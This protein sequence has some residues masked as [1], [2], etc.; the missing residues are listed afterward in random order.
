MLFGYLHAKYYHEI[1]F[2]A[3]ERLH[4]FCILH[5]AFSIAPIN[6]NLP[7][8]PAAVPLPMSSPKANTKVTEQMDTA[9]AM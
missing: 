8:Y 6:S 2:R 7:F 4:Q 5:F 3:S 9:A 1:G